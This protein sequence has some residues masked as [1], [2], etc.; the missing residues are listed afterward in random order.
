MS[1]DTWEE[2]AKAVNNSARVRGRIVRF[3]PNS[4][5]RTEKHPKIL[6][7]CFGREVGAFWEKRAKNGDYYLSGK[8]F[9]EQMTIFERGEGVWRINARVRASQEARI[10]E[11][12]RVLGIEP[13]ADVEDIKSLFR[14][15]AL[16][17][18]PD[19]GG[20]SEIFIKIRAAYEEEL[21][22]L[23]VKA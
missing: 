16:Q 18:H 8:L 2:I 20:D 14:R 17:H 21:C 22:E 13:D 19:H 23:A 1:A 6:A 12:A 5:Y 7:L 9:D 4:Q 11:W 3:V 15:L 10:P